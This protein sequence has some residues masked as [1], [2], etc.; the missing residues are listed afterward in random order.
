[1]KIRK[2][3][4]D[5]YV[6]TLCIFFLSFFD[7]IPGL[8]S[9]GFILG[10]IFIIKYFEINT[11]QVI[12]IIL[13]PII[14][15]AI[16]LLGPCDNSILK[17]TASLILMLVFLKSVNNFTKILSNNFNE[18][19]IFNPNPIMKFLLVVNFTA[20]IIDAFILNTTRPSG[21]FFSEPSHLG[22]L[23]VPLTLSFIL[24]RDVIFSTLG[25]FTLLI[26]YSSSGIVL[27]SS[28]LIIIVIL[29]TLRTI[30]IFRINA[31]Q[32]MIICTAFGVA[33]LVATNSD[34]LARLQGVMNSPSTGNN[35]NLSSLVY[36]NG[37]VAAFQYLSQTNLL[38]VGF[39]LMGCEGGMQTQ[40]SAIIIEVSGAY[41]NYNDGSFLMSKLISE[42]GIFVVPLIFAL[43][44]GV[45][46]AVK[47]V[48][49]V[50]FKNRVTSAIDIFASMF[51]LSGF[52]FLFI[53]GSG[54]FSIPFLYIIFSYGILRN[55]RTKYSYT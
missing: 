10:F 48:I 27:L 26:S 28:I 39:N 14:N 52:I 15:V 37:W 34:T 13:Y 43:L 29:T 25:I 23:A 16:A 18:N 8:P 47:I 31:F 4:F 24:Q 30:C 55:N 11:S 49:D 51:F 32:A 53:R 41:L 6:F 1:M 40:I 5:Y 35:T 21:L 54:Y 46:T 50:I 42:I 17:S 36:L 45:L 7:L 38:G 33:F 9:L 19:L 44:P 2:L 22:I 3:N 12:F 20:I